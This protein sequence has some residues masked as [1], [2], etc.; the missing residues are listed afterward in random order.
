MLITKRTP[1]E[2]KD[3]KVRQ[4][5]LMPVPESPVLGVVVSNKQRQVDCGA[6]RPKYR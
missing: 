5:G 6:H 2:Q 3:R 1:V 4:L